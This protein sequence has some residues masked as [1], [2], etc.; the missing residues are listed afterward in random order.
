M[1]SFNRSAKVY[2]CVGVCVAG[3]TD[4][5]KKAKHKPSN[6]EDTF[7]T[8]NDLCDLLQISVWTALKMINR[9]KNTLPSVRLGHRTRRFSRN[10]V[11]N[12]LD[13]QQT[14]KAS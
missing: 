6:N 2:L 7:L 4:S 10:A 5:R 13:A 8:M 11:M 12:W 1:R 9:K 14:P 3:V